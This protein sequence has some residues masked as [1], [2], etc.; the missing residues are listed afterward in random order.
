L[1]YILDDENGIILDKVT[2]DR[3]IILTKARMTQILAIFTEIFQSSAQPIIAEAFKAA[4]ERYIK[5]TAGEKKTDMSEF[6][7]TSA[8]RFT[9]AGLGKIE[10]VQFTPETGEVKF[11][12]YTNFFAEIT[13]NG[14]TYC[15]GVAAFVTGM[16]KAFLHITPNVKETKCIG[17]NDPYCE[18]HM[19]Q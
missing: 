11:R 17:K 16:Y 5:E 2:H 7:K 12:I 3:C 1:E 10:I 14:T 18:W 4:G 13:H 8:K 15:N 6:L 19:T 9:D